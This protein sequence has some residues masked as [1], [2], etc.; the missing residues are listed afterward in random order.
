MKKSKKRQ[1]VSSAC[2]YRFLAALV[3]LLISGN[4]LLVSTLIPET[5]EWYSDRIYRPAAAAAVLMTGLPP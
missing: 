1:A 5:A 2:K 4:L 3:F